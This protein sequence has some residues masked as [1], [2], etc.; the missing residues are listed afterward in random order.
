[1]PNEGSSPPE[2]KRVVVAKESGRYVG[3]EPEG[4]HSRP[5]PAAFRRAAEADS[6]EGLT[7]T[8]H[9]KYINNVS[10]REGGGEGKLRR[11][12]PSSF[13]S[14]SLRFYPVLGCAFLSLP[15]SPAFTT[16]LLGG[17]APESARRIV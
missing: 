5:P 3:T 2:P 15:P 8:K 14:D 1:M 16:H 9:R 12:A 4:P 10:R 6:E 7:E 13:H 17:W 11:A